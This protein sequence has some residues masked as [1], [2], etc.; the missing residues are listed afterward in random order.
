[1]R[2]SSLQNLLTFLFLFLTG[3]VAAQS[4]NEGKYYHP[5]AGYYTFGINGGW[6][7][8]SSDVRTDFDGWGV[9][10]TLGKNLYYRPGAP[11]SFDVRGRLLYANM[12]GFDGKKSFD[13][14]ENDAL[15]G[16][17]GPDYTTY[18]AALGVDNG[19]VYQ[20]HR[21]D[22]GELAVEGVFRLNRLRE[23]TGV[24]VGLYGGVGIDGY[25]TRTDQINS[26]TKLP[27][28]AEY[29]GLSDDLSTSAAANRLKNGILDGY[30]ETNADGFADGVQFDWMPSVGLELGY[31][32]TP[33]FAVM[34]GHR[35]TFTRNN[36]ID[37]VQFSDTNN[38]LYHYTTLG[39]EWNLQA[40]EKK[41]RK[42]EIDLRIPTYVPF[43]QNSRF[44]NVRA[45]IKY[46]NSSADVEFFVNNR[47]ENF[48]YN[49]GNFAANFDLQP[50]R[51][52]IVIVASNL[53]GTDREAFLIIW[54][55]DNVI[56]VPNPPTTNN[57]P[58]GNAPRVRF[59]TPA[60]DNERTE[61]SRLRVRAT[62]EGVNGRNDL[63]F[64]LNGRSENFQ[65]D[66]RRNELTAD[67]VLRPGSNT[68]TVRASNRFGNDQATRRITLE[69]VRGDAPVVRIQSPQNNATVNRPGID[70]TATV[71]NV[72]RS[73]EITV[74]LN[75]R[76]VGNVNLQRGRF[77]KRLNL[78]E[79][80]NTI[81]V[82]AQNRFGSDLD[83]VTV[84]YTERVVIEDPQTPPE[85]RITTP[86]NNS[87]VDNQRIDLRATVKNVRN[88]RDVNVTV[89]GGN[90]TDFDYNSLSG[91]LT[92]KVNLTAGSN[93][94]RVRATNADG[95]DEATVR[96]TLRAGNKPTV[97]IT[98]P[99][100]NS[101][102]SNTQTA[103]VIAQITEVP[104][105][106]GITVEINGRRTTNFGYTSGGRLNVQASLRE[107]NNTVR[108]IGQNQYGRDEETVNI[109]YNAPKNP[110]T[111][112]ISAP[113]NGAK[114]SDGQV[115]VTATVKNATRNEVTVIA[116]GRTI[117]NWTLR[118]TKL[119]ATLTQRPGAHSLTI[120]AANR[121]G[122][123]EA[124]VNYTISAPAAKPTVSITEPARDGGT[125]GT[126]T[127][128]FAATVMNVSSKSE[129]SV[130]LNGRSVNFTYNQRSR[131]VTAKLNLAINK[132]TVTV[133]V[134]NAGGSDQDSRTITYKR[135][136]TD[137]PTTAGPEIVINSVSS[138]ATNPFEP[139][140]AKS[141]VIATLEGVTSRSQITFTYKGATNNS[142]TFD[143]R[144]KKF[145][146]TVDLTRGANPFKIKV[147]TRTGRDE[148]S[149][150][151]DF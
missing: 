97:N 20:N 149:R 3:F 21:T 85:V 82:R 126:A 1:M 30:A 132:N 67:V 38:D 130:K 98:Q 109:R 14:A 102:T 115:K 93:T 45:N 143:K 122:R 81:V 16:R 125:V 86:T 37:G 36:Y 144:T 148:E 151:I 113:R 43:T 79:G 34:A 142:Y 28:Y 110:P 76:N 55:E 8:Q 56:S 9:G 137:I 119:S 5:E 74:T 117:T 63:D 150:V 46:V 50:G 33:N 134:Q 83:R 57:T 108:V 7:Y 77:S 13:I 69:E 111:V 90:I 131:T 64:A 139:D 54:Q 145:V 42:P 31:Q 32:F 2:L 53:V 114:L 26:E 75:G 88:K 71:Q 60:R 147:Q 72:T 112:S 23:N 73:N 61:N 65:Y 80:N 89:N 51:N 6:A 35:T 10:L 103:T 40:K 39:L 11:L 22:L 49:N 4:S 99:A 140:V 105:K 78:R 128:N 44:A 141:T 138:P 48:T 52:E 68:L 101:T 95:Q 100:G 129:I 66:N 120:E 87:T 136:T 47:S 19:F 104:N 135:K 124:T 84:R 18:P 92:A 116:D 91:L 70:L 59:T 27:Y 127:A 15:N 123:D 106:S 146:V 96:V 58:T 25:L 94:I 29:A 17:D 121:D 12:R 107:G 41:Q 118:G 62:V 133:S 24:L